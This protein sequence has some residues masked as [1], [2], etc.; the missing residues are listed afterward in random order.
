MSCAQRFVGHAAELLSKDPFQSVWKLFHSLGLKLRFKMRLQWHETVVVRVVQSRQLY[1]FVLFFCIADFIGHSLIQVT[2]LNIEAAST[3]GR[4]TQYSPLCN[5]F[6]LRLNRNSP[7][8]RF[9]CYFSS[10]FHLI[11]LVFNDYSKQR[12]RVN[13]NGPGF[14]SLQQFQ[15]THVNAH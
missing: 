9:I 3:G 10:S 11:L 7:S 6:L 13:L 12:R 2:F 5:F 4:E 15:I 1:M 14:F 8:R